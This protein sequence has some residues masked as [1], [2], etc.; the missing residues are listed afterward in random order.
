MPLTK[1]KEKAANYETLFALTG[2]RERSWKL[3]MALPDPE[4]PLTESAEVIASVIGVSAERIISERASIA[5]AFASERIETNVLYPEHPYFPEERGEFF[6]VIYA[7]GNLELLKKRKVT[8]LGMPRPSM[9]GKSDALD[10]LGCLMKEDV[11]VLLTLDD[12]LPVFAAQFLLNNSG[13]VIAVLPSPVSKC[14]D[15]EQAM[16][17]GRIYASG[18]LLSVFPPSQKIERWLVMVRNSFLSSITEAAFL[19]E[20]KDGGPS[21]AVFD[22]VLASGGRA[23]LS[24]SMLEVPSYTFAAKRI[25]NGALTFS[26]HRDLKRII[27][28]ARK[29]IDGSDLFSFS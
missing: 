23:M 12:G 3:L 29:E 10:A 21:W 14:Q 15:K 24:S 16:L 17:R 22:R 26:S 1:D 13:N 6:P 28:R 2:D 4:I 9:Q 11:T 5:S 7:S 20:E 25:N 27:P 18:L 19:A 8:F